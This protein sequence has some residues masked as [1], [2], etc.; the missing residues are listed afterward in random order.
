[1][2]RASAAFFTGAASPCAPP[3]LLPNQIHPHPH[4][5]LWVSPYPVWQE[6]QGHLRCQEVPDSAGPQIESRRITHISAEQKR[7]FNIKLGFDTLHSLV[8]TL[9]TQ[10][11][12]KVSVQGRADQLASSGHA[13]AQGISWRSCAP[14]LHQYAWSHAQVASDLQPV[15]E[16]S[17]AWQWGAQDL[18]PFAASAL[19][20]CRSA[21]PPPCRR[22]LS[23]YA[24]CSRSG[25]PSRMRHSGCGSRSRSSTAQSSRETQPGEVGGSCYLCWGSKA[26]QAA[27]P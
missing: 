13:G 2:A 22:Q 9:S 10:P 17:K 3:S 14:R 5:K 7:R 19:L 1:M 27:V 26:G 18:M 23:T 21:R 24:S 25:Q 11:S 20:S 4:C 12:I 8:S 16:T 6:A 15:A